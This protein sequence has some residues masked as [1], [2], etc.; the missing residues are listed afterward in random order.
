MDERI[1]RYSQPYN[2][3]TT[4]TTDAPM[5][6]KDWIKA[7]YGIIPSTAEKQYQ[8]YLLQ[9]YRDTNSSETL[10][11]I[12]MNNDYLSL[13]ESLKPL[14]KNDKNLR[15]FATVD[16]SDPTQLSISLPYFAQKLKEL[17]VYYISKR[18]ELKTIKIQ[19]SIKGSERGLEAIL[20]NKLINKFTIGNKVEILDLDENLPELS[21]VSSDFSID[22]QALN[23]YTDYSLESNADKIDNVSD[24]P[25]LYVLGEYISVLYNA[26]SLEDVPLSALEIPHDSTESCHSTSILN[27]ENII[28]LNKK[29][30]GES[31]NFI[32]GGYY[33]NLYN[34]IDYNITMGNNQFLFPTNDNKDDIYSEISLNDFGLNTVA[35]FSQELSSSDIILVDDGTTLKGAWFGVSTADIDVEMIAVLQNGK[36]F[37]FPFP[38]YGK[39]NPDNSWSGASLDDTFGRF[40]S[41]F[42][43][44]NE[45][46]A[47]EKQAEDLYWTTDFSLT[48]SNDVS[49]HESTLISDGAFADFKYK[50]SDHIIVNGN[51]FAWLYDIQK[52]QIPITVDNNLIYFPIQ[53][54]DTSDE[55]VIEYP[56]TGEISINSLVLNSTFLGAVASYDIDTADMVIELDSYGKEIS[57]AWLYSPQ[58]DYKPAKS[59][60]CQYNPYI[61][62]IAEIYQSIDAHII[63]DN[64]GS[65]NTK[66]PLVN[67]S[68]YQVAKE[69]LI[70]FAKQ[71]TIRN[72]RITFLNSRGGGTKSVTTSWFD[73]STPTGKEGFA[74]YCDS[75]EFLPADG[76]TNY[77]RVLEETMSAWSIPTFPSDLTH[78]YFIS[79]GAPN[80]KNSYI[81]DTRKTKWQ[82]FLV[83]NNI[84]N[85]F[86]IGIPPLM[87]GNNTADWSE[88]SAQQNLKNIAYPQ[89]DNPNL[90]DDDQNTIILQNTTDL[91][92]FLYSTNIKIT[93]TATATTKK[94]Y[95]TGLVYE[96]G[97][98]QP[99]LSFVVKHGEHA[100]FIWEST[101]TDINNIREFR[102]FSHEDY[103]DYTDANNN[104][105][106]PQNNKFTYDNYWKNCTCQ[107][108]YRSPF[109]HKGNVFSDNSSYSDYIV[110][111]NMPTFDPVKWRGR[112][113]LPIGES[114]DFA[115]FRLNSDQP[116]PIAGWGE[117][118]WVNGKGDPFSLSRG[119]MYNYIRNGLENGPTTELPYF[120]I[121]HPYC[122]Q[123]YCYWRGAVRNENGAWVDAATLSDLSLKYGEHYRYVHR[124]HNSFVTSR[125]TLN[126]E[127]VD[128]EFV[129][130]SP[131][132]GVISYNVSEMKN[133]ST[134]FLM[135]VEVPD[136]TPFWA[137]AE[138]QQNNLNLLLPK[139]RTLIFDYVQHIQPEFSDIIFHTGDT[140]LFERGECS[141]EKCFSWNQ[142]ISLSITNPD[143][144]GT[145]YEIDLNNCYNSTILD[146]LIN[147]TCETCYTPYNE[148]NE[149]LCDSCYENVPRFI[150]EVIFGKCS[151]GAGICDPTI[152]LF[153]PT[154]T[155]SDIVFNKSTKDTTINITYLAQKDIS[156]STTLENIG[157]GSPPTGGLWVDAVTGTYAESSEPWKNLLNSEYSV[158]ISTPSL[159]RLY[160]VYE[161]GLNIPSQLGLGKYEMKKGRV[162]YTNTE[163]LTG[164]KVYRN[165]KYFIDDGFALDGID[166]S[167]MKIQTGKAVG[168]IIPSKHKRFS[169]YTENIEILNQHNDYAHASHTDVY[170][171]T[172]ILLKNDSYSI[173]DRRGKNGELVVKDWMGSIYS[174]ADFVPALINHVSVYDET[175]VRSIEMYTDD[176]L[177][178]TVLT[179]EEYL[180]SPVTELVDNEISDINVF[181]DVVGINTTNSYIL[182]KSIEIGDGTRTIDPSS[183]I[184]IEKNNISHWFDVE[185]NIVWLCDISPHPIIL[186]YDIGNNILREVYNMSADWDFGY[187][188]LGSPAININGDTLNLLFVGENT[189]LSATYLYN[190]EFVNISE[191]TLSCLEISALTGDFGNKRILEY[192]PYENNNILLLEVQSYPNKILTFMI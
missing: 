137:K 186:R 129:E 183:V 98:K 95:Y 25:L 170:G 131:S 177:T 179:S 112:D 71:D 10:Q 68:K 117:G 107:S 154:F 135:T 61:T 105:I 36:K 96:G 127:Y 110:L 191:N 99:S 77:I 86:S 73:I 115:W 142:P 21:T 184:L 132:D 176:A 165:P 116:D 150:K 143:M 12:Q 189:A 104:S 161:L 101:S 32:T 82:N 155:P 57:A 164:T 122:N 33:T 1:R 2:I 182:Y 167:W 100:K 42:P 18:E 48:A 108:A 17:A 192:Y 162:L 163:N 22:I 53:R 181:Y 30:L 14:F 4:P 40:L 44:K 24:N 156:F 26:Y 89:V 52:T 130:Y 83:S 46:L 43:T 133:N 63:L 174:F 5:A 147:G 47:A 125:F 29:Y 9:W 102:G 45:T 70:D 118:E 152:T 41:F 141:P 80:P 3:S 72:I 56:K 121:N 160:P 11:A 190:A 166:S 180:F 38:N 124:P 84:D 173:D 23:D 134:N 113:G 158:V 50:N 159:D 151:C 187:S 136:A 66:D 19:R 75:S 67:K 123:N 149:Q 168:H 35:T 39:I 94:T 27:H 175:R 8:D 87:G 16:L 144:A 109:G 74:K 31:Y 185:K 119:E 62:S 90:I 106:V 114:I 15:R 7:N 60:G 28:E 51:Q 69:A 126:G 76:W 88:E 20:R 65:M 145:W 97:S 34:H 148:S 58:L 59:G 171:N 64:S 140:V 178:A 37:K 92:Q 128:E 139:E 103:C 157:N 120:V 188:I 172:Y 169:G 81:D 78:I 153:K 6:F 111:D 79:D 55:I 13:L 93:N 54:Y 138:Y 91:R 146:H 49:I 85:C